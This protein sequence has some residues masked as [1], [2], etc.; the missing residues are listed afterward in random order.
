MELENF[1]RKKEMTDLI[2]SYHEMRLNLTKK[3][4]K[5]QENFNKKRDKLKNLLENFPI[6]SQYV[7][8]T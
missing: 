6:D 7:V 2:K 3:K 4:L 5:I 1:K 8:E